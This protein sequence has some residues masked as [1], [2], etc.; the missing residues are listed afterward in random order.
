MEKKN[1]KKLGFIFEQQF[2]K[3][4]REQGYGV[5][6]QMVWSVK[7]VRSGKGVRECF[8]F[9]IIIIDNLPDIRYRQLL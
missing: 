9:V 1:I 3:K 7:I 5:K 6:V 8:F 4:D 2:N